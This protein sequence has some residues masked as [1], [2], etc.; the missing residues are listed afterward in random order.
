ME[1]LFWSL[2]DLPTWFLSGSIL[3]NIPP[4]D[5]SKPKQDLHWEGPRRYL[6]SPSQTCVAGASRPSSSAPDKGSDYP[7]L[8]CRQ[9][10][11][12]GSPWVPPQ[13]FGDYQQLLR[14]SDAS[15]LVFLSWSSFLERILVTPTRHAGT[16]LTVAGTRGMTLWHY[17]AACAAATEHLQF[18]PLARVR[19]LHRSWPELLFPKWE[20]LTHDPHCN[21][22]PV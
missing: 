12:R 5:Y 9:L 13:A 19:T 10:G 1:I 11:G 14:R 21:R 2:P 4:E 7:V 3:N 18:H 15:F 16:T 20:K 8:N 6:W 22:N 17:A